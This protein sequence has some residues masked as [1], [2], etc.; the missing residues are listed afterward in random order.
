MNNALSVGVIVIWSSYLNY[1]QM[2]LFDTNFTKRLCYYI[3]LFC[4]IIILCMT[5]RSLFV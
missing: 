1:V 5:A 4:V 2:Q 3:V